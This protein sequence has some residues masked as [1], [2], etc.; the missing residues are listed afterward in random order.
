[1]KT[2][3][4]RHVRTELQ[5]PQQELRRRRVE[6]KHQRTEKHR[7]RMHLKVAGRFHKQEVNTFR[8]DEVIQYVDDTATSV[9]NPGFSF[10]L[11]VTNVKDLFLIWFLKRFRK[12]KS[13]LSK[14]SCRSFLWD[15][16][17]TDFTSESFSVELHASGLV[18]FKPSRDA[19]GLGLGLGLVTQ[20]RSNYPLIAVFTDYYK[21]TRSV[22]TNAIVIGSSN[23]CVILLASRKIWFSL[24]LV[25]C[26][27]QKK[28]LSLLSRLIMIKHLL[29]WY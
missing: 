13:S 10:Y 28:E 24:M 17:F 16:W 6:G 29:P 27:H 14:C 3:P 11:Y 4:K 5:I 19:A 15:K 1:M 9:V 7:E 18:F 12:K 25:F 23:W 8:I 22:K 21:S 2:E 20:K 26:L